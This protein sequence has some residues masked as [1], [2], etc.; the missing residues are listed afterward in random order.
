MAY[1]GIFLY[2]GILITALIV[3]FNSY[4]KVK[5]RNTLIKAALYH[6][7]VNYSETTNEKQTKDTSLPSKAYGLAIRKFRKINHGLDDYIF[8]FDVLNHQ[9]KTFGGRNA[10]LQAARRRHFPK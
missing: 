1:E 3:G 7:F 9:V 2:A 5:S 4:K 6:Y 10:M 8:C